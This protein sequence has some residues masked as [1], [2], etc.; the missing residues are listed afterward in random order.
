MAGLVAPLL[1]TSLLGLAIGSLVLFS[2]AWFIWTRHLR[3]A[4]I[5]PTTP[6]AAGYEPLDGM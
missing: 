6:D 5:A 4:R 2:V 1:G 3:A